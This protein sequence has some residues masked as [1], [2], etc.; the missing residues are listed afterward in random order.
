MQIFKNCR[1]VSN[2]PF[3]STAGRPWINLAS[4]STTRTQIT[5]NEYL[6]LNGI[7]YITEKKFERKMKKISGFFLLKHADMEINTIFKSSLA[8]FVVYKLLSR[9]NGR[10]RIYRVTI[11][12]SPLLCKH[13]RFA[14]LLC[15][16]S[17]CQCLSMS[18]SQQ[19]AHLRNNFQKDR[20]RTTR[21]PTL[22]LQ[23]S[24]YCRFDKAL[25]RGM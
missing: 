5:I 25:V 14:S 19:I 18:F 15:I 9:N 20:S 1:K 10:H 13:Q 21:F 11:S 7:F 16:T 22:F 8:S 17:V 2:Y 4:I 24:I 6:I 12:L 23:V 3:S